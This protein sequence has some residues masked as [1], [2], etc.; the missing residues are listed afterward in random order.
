ML[1]LLRIGE[2]MKRYIF[3]A[4]AAFLTTGC[5]P[6][7]VTPK[8]TEPA[9]IKTQTPAVI[10]PQST[11]T[12][13]EPT[14]MP[15]EIAPGVFKIP[16]EATSQTVETRQ[17]PIPTEEVIEEQ[18]N[19][20]SYRV[21][22]KTKK[23]TF[24]DTGFLVTYSDSLNLNVLAM[25]KSVLDLKVKLNEDDACVGSLCN[26][27]HGFNQSFLDGRYP[28]SFIQNILQKKPIFN[29]RN[30]TKTSTGFVQKIICDRF[31]IKYQVSK[32][33][34]YFKDKKNNILIKLKEIN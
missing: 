3:L 4:L 24:S 11:I 19:S 2:K 9:K 13:P 28:D 5:I 7:Y 6:K 21:T 23:F 32:N 14:Q 18:K 34:V 33:S 8:Q 29:G 10:Q 22:M 30:L 17:L 25:G 26:S 20:K 31:G 12:K 1:V 16:E 15:V 27:K